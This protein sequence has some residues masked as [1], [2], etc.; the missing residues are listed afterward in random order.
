MGE[1][2]SKEFAGIPAEVIIFF[3]VF[4]ILTFLWASGFLKTIFDMLGTIL[5]VVI[6]NLLSLLK[7][8]LSG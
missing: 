3:I 8:F 7:S 4:I 2:T 6:G 5:A 1:V